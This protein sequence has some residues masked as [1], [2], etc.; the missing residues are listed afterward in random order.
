MKTL[1]IIDENGQYQDKQG[2]RYNLLYCKWAKGQRADE[3]KEFT[4]LQDAI[5]YYGLTEVGK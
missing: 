3:F 2:K 1:L 4:S 5:K